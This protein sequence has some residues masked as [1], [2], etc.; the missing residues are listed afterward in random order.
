MLHAYFYTCRGSIRAAL[1]L[2]NVQSSLAVSPCAFYIALYTFIMISYVIGRFIPTFPPFWAS[3]RSL[4][5]SALLP[6]QIW[7]NLTFALLI[8]YFQMVRIK[9]TDMI[10]QPNIS[11]TQLCLHLYLHHLS[12]CLSLCI[13]I[14]PWA[15]YFFFLSSTFPLYT[16]TASPRIPLHRRILYQSYLIVD[17]SFFYGCLSATYECTRSLLLSFHRLNLRR[18]STSFI[19]TLIQIFLASAINLSN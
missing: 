10:S 2:F 7:R 3:S 17:F 6:L 4:K 1:S 19:L 15:S 16:A 12:L 13:S 5:F 9:R 8:A 11:T 14:F 18:F